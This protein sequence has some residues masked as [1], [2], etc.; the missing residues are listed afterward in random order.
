MKADCRKFPNQFNMQ[1]P[2]IRRNMNPGILEF[3][4]RNAAEARRLDSADWINEYKINGRCSIKKTQSNCSQ[5]F[6]EIQQLD[7]GLTSAVAIRCTPC[8]AADK[9]EDF[10]TLSMMKAGDF[11]IHRDGRN[12]LEMLPS[13]ILLHPQNG[14]E[15]DSGYF[16]GFLCDIDHKRFQ[17]TAQAIRGDGTQLNLD[18]SYMLNGEEDCGGMQRPLW[19]LFSFVDQML[20]ESTYLAANLGLDEQI[21]RVLALSLFQAEG[22]LETIQNRWKVSTNNWTNRLDD[23]VDYI[24]QNAHHNL[25]LTD[26][27][28]QSRYSGRHLQNMF[29]ERFDCTPMQFVRRQR[30]SAAMEKLQTADLDDTVTTIARDMGYRYTSNFTNDFQREFGVKPSV[31]LRSSRGRSKAVATGKSFRPRPQPYGGSNSSIGVHFN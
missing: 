7:L 1:E 28:E 26:L 30:L 5:P 24:R 3:P 13:S 15:I 18:R 12:H 6:T 17:R 2:V 11:C 19:L 22:E 10:S 29:K 23:L 20:A 16:S 31:V 21:Y 14:E 4:L 8:I 25:T 27:E 9:G